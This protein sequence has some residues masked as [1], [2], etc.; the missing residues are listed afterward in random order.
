VEVG[1]T[2]QHR[3]IPAQENHHT[4]DPQKS[5]A[6]PGFH[7][8]TGCNTVSSFSGIEKKKAFDVWRSYPDATDAFLDLSSAST[9]TRPRTQELLKRFVVLCH[10]RTR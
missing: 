4:P 2:Q 7:A 6:L 9:A 1:V 8:F 3:V 5:K 10:E